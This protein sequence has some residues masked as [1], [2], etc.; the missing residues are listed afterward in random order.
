M[1]TNGN[2]ACTG[3]KSAVVPVDNGQHHVAL[4]AVEAPQNWFEDFGSGRLASGAATINLDRTFAQTVDST[5]DYHVFLTPESDCRGLYVTNKTASG[6]EVHE[7]GGGQSN[8]PFA[9]RIVALRRGY[10]NVRLEDMTDR[11]NNIGMAQPKAMSGTQLAVP[12]PRAHAANGGADN[13][14]LAGMMKTK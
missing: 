11:M 5:S 13:A 2:L 9:Y 14:A 12:A 6:F 8:V 7:L 3:A 4:Y 10:E 1:D